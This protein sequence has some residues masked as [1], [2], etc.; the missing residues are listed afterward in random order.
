MAANVLRDRIVERS[1]DALL[2]HPARLHIDPAIVFV[3]WPGLPVTN[4]ARH[5]FV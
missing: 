3:L 4:D 5:A 1:V 2:E